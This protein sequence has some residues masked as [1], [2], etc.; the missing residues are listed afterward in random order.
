MTPKGKLSVSI[1]SP[2]HGLSVSENVEKLTGLKLIINPIIPKF[3]P[4]S[5]SDSKEFKLTFE[6][7]PELTTAG[8]HH[9]ITEAG[10]NQMSKTFKFY[11][12]KHED[13]FLKMIHYEGI[14][15]WDNKK[16]HKLR[17]EYDDYKK[18]SYYA[19]SG[20]TVNQI[21]QE[22][23]IN[24]AKIKE[25]NPEIGIKK[26]LY[27]N[28]KIIITNHYSKT[29]IPYINM[30]LSLLDEIGVES[31]FIGNIIIVKPNTTTLKPKTFTVESD[32]S[33]ASYYFSIA[34]LSE[35]GTEINLSSYKENSLQGDSALVSIYKH[36]GV[37]ASFSENKLTLKKEKSKWKLTEHK[38][39]F[40]KN[41]LFFSLYNVI[42]HQN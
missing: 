8:G 3:L 19:K 2:R 16:C 23:L 4:L 20:E 24:I 11:M 42:N 40:L 15:K 34:A 30:T 32:W 17:I 10:F 38:I 14:F 27:E 36:F 1:L 33:S 5:V 37:S 39:D 7:I 25:L 29:S 26:S 28:Q 9:Y 12:E 35:V 18:I 22:K 21:C 41:Q 31:S 6:D 13:V